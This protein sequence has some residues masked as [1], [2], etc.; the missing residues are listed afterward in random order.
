[1]PSQLPKMKSL[2]ISKMVPKLTEADI[3][4][5][6]F[7][8][9][10]GGMWSFGHLELISKNVP[11]LVLSNQTNQLSWGDLTSQDITDCSHSFLSSSAIL[12]GQVKVETRLPTPALSGVSENSNINSGKNGNGDH[13]NGSVS[14]STN[15]ISLLEST[16]ITWTKQIKNVLKQD[17]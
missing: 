7:L 3:H 9:E 16:I 8:A 11:L 5:G 15:R 14:K 17:P 10:I 1:M 13:S 6:T 12:C 2:A 4:A